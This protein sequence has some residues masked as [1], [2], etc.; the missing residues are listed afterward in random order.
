MGQIT[1]SSSADLAGSASASAT[2]GQSATGGE[3]ELGKITWLSSDEDG[4]PDVGLILGLG[5]GASLY[6]GEISNREL[7]DQG[8]DEAEHSG[9]GWWVT[10]HTRG[11]FQIVGP[12]ADTEAARE[13]VDHVFAGVQ[14]A[15][16]SKAQS[17]SPSNASAT[18]LSTDGLPS[19]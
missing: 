12:V 4:G 2:E 17:I 11:G 7:R 18:A 1:G 9:T 19:S 13:L 6:V 5:D 14:A 3:D 8:L 15:L 10:L 16:S